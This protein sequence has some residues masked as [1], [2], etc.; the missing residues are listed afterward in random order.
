M[1]SRK[2]THYHPSYDLCGFWLPMYT[3]EFHYKT[4]GVPVKRI[5]F[6]V[7]W[8][9]VSLAQQAPSTQQQELTIRSIYTPNGIPDWMPEA[10]K[11]S[12]DGNKVSYFLR[13]E[14]G[15]KIQLYYIDVATGKSAVLVASEKLGSMTPPT[16]KNKD[17]R[18]KDNRARYNVAPYHWAPDSQHILFDVY[19]QLWLHTLATGTSVALSSSGDP[20]SDPKFSPDG[21]RLSYIK[22]H[23][24]RVQPIAGGEEIALTH[25]Q[26]DNLLNGEVDWV[27]AEELA[28]RSNYFWSPNGKKIVFLQMDETKVPTYPIVDFIP[29]HPTVSEE[30]YPKVGD[31]NPEVRLGVI[32]SDGGKPH[33]IRLTDNKDIY[34]PRF[35]WVRDD[36]I[37]ATVLNRAQNQLD[38]YFFES[39]TGKS[40]KV[41]SEK[42]D[43]WIE[44]DDNFSILKSG[45]KFIWPSWRDGHTHLYLYSFDKNS[46]LSSDAKLERQ[47][48]KG[49]FEVFSVEG[50]DESSNTLYAT[51]NALD[52]RQR[53]L[54]SI[55]LD[56]SDFRV[57]T[58]EEPGTH[59]ADFSPN[60]KGYIDDFSALMTP[61][62]MSFCRVGGNCDVL[63]KAR[64]LDRYNLTAPQFVDF[65]AED[66]TKLHG[67]LYLPAQSTGKKVPL[68]MNPYGG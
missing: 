1:S 23:N 25:D 29:Q 9:G 13:D 18:E 68:L 20:I 43:T 65:Q 15:G 14:N 22:R 5:L 4:Y 36:L 19:G 26:D 51:T 67:L 48:T 3:S 54:C 17:D 59:R 10:I 46:P 35:G 49:D 58:K 39:S 37:W 66:G 21:K 32:N 8:A 40:H 7:L 57:L 62:R 6:I 60:A 27:Y 42:S 47:I 28:V 50:V 33:W 55:K 16:S 31:P 34:I 24:L 2:M 30:K 45:D 12:P 38:L 41:L 56:G 63:W 44:T 53:H 64:G 52:D 11:W 61:P